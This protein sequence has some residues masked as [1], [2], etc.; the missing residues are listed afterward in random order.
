MF[1]F[2]EKHESVKM[3]AVK[4][5]TRTEI[6]RGTSSKNPCFCATVRQIPPR[7]ENACQSMS[8]S[9]RIIGIEGRNYVL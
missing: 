4:V 1:G 2:T 9:C 6:G 8:I 5:S 7:K 3:R